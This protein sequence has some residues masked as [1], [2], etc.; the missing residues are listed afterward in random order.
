MSSYTDLI[1]ITPRML[2]RLWGRDSLGDWCAG[3]PRPGARVGEIWSCHGGNATEAGQHLDAMVRAGPNQMLGDLGRAPPSVRLIL[4]GEPSDPLQHDGRLALWRVLESPLDAALTATFPD[5]RTRRMR[6]RRGDIMRV[7]DRVALGLDSGVVAIE[8]RPT[9]DP[10]NGAAHS[11]PFRRLIAS[12][13]KSERQTMLRDPSLSVELWTLPATSTIQPDGETC[14]VL[15]ALTSGVC[16]DGR[17]LARGQ[18]VFVPANGGAAVLTGHGA[19]LMVSY[20]DLVPTNI[21]RHTP[22][23]DPLNAAMGEA[24]LLSISA[25]HTNQGGAIRLAA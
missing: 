8:V 19:K 15:T 14:H 6:W 20:P 10:D 13:E 23:P 17:E 7:D 24:A 2:P 18:S 11:K 25:D 9:F 1:F 3:H 22:H 5:G 21:W 16:I 12:R 4:T